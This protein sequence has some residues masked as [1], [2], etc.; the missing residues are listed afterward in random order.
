MHAF[1]IYAAILFTTSNR[2]IHV[3][4]MAMSKLAKDGK[5]GQVG[6]SYN[7]Y[8]LPSTYYIIIIILVYVIMDCQFTSGRHFI[9]IAADLI[10]LPVTY[11][12]HRYS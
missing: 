10:I 4:I 12:H 11:V 1:R 8:S 3:Y 7:I 9:G 6:H 2:G 5:I